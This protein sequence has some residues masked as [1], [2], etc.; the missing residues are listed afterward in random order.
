MAFWLYSENS[1]GNQVVADKHGI[2]G[3]PYGFRVPLE[4]SVVISGVID[5]QG[6]EILCIL[7]HY[8][9]LSIWNWLSFDLVLEHSMEKNIKEIN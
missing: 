2:L 1:I 7:P 9:G 8:L 3:N 5:G 4:D 6:S